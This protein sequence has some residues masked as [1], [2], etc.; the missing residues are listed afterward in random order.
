MMPHVPAGNAGFPPLERVRLENLACTTP[1]DHGLELTHWSVRSLQQVAV[2]QA[3]IPTVHYTTVA[4]ILRTAELQPH[5]WRYWKTTFWAQAAIEQA[6]QILECYEQVDRWLERGEIVIGLD[7]K[8]NIQALERTVPTRPMVWG[9][10]ERQEFEYIRHGTVNLLVALL[11]HDGQMW[12]ECLDRNDGEHFR[13]AVRRLLEALGWAKRIHLIMDNGPSHASADTKA[14]FRDLSPWVR[15]LY[16][17][18]HASWLNQGELLLRAFSDRYLLRGDWASRQALVDHLKTSW[19][20]YN[21]RFAHP[22]TWSWT[23]RDFHDWLARKA[24]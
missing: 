9:Q 15:V 6:V 17:P 10:M 7:E 19:P 20:E 4:V 14:F 12:A 8:P 13:P 16:T 3:V 1:A 22:F 11:V 24:A 18:P 21:A 5:R 23:R 2:E